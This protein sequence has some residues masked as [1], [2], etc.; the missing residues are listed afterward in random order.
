MARQVEEDI[1][2]VVANLVARASSDSGRTSRQVVA[3]AE[4]RARIAPSRGFRL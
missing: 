2:R 4:S 3:A 1:D